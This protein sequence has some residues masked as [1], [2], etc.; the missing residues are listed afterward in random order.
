MIKYP[1]WCVEYQSI[2][3]MNNVYPYDNSLDKKKSN[4]SKDFWK[5][6]SFIILKS[7]LHVEKESFVRFYSSSIHNQ[8]VRISMNDLDK[9]KSF[10]INRRFWF[11]RFQI[12]LIKHTMKSKT[13]R[14][15]PEVIDCVSLGSNKNFLVDS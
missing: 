11:F 4:L 6:E 1:K 9:T 10:K 3:F 5:T 13:D 15:F 2:R 7:F 14:L 8:I 12:Q